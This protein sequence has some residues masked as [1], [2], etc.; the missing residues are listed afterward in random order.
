MCRQGCCKAD[1]AGNPA[2]TAITTFIIANDPKIRSL[3][4][5]A[6]KPFSQPLKAY[7]EGGGHKEG[8]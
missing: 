7:E 5:P 3:F 1:N 8:P 2:P 6:E 4:H